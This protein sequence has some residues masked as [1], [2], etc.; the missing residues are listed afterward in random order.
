MEGMPGT[1]FPQLIMSL[2]LE[3]IANQRIDLFNKFGIPIL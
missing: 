1:L 2:V 3:M